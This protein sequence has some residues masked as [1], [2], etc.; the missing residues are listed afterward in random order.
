MNALAYQA[1][2]ED[3]EGRDRSREIR[4]EAIDR[5]KETLILRRVTHLDQL[6]DKLNE[7]RVRRVIMPMLAGSVDWE[8]TKRDLEYVRDLGLAARASPARIANP[9]YA[10]VAPRE[11]TDSLQSGLAGQV[12]PEWYVNKDRGLDMAELLEAFQSYFREH[13]ESWVERYGHREAGPQLVLHAYL[14]RVVRRYGQV[15]REYAVGRGW[16]DLVIEWRLGGG[17]GPVPTLKHVIECKVRS[18][19]SGLEIL[20]REGREQTATYMDRCGAKSGHLVIFDVRPRKSWD[21][22]IFR[23]DPEQDARP[24]TVWEM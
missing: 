10:E 12:D 6:A 7:D 14:R 20:I 17:P 9:I 11:L 8:Y 2:F 16:S 23:T 3:D 22:R 5:A 4:V 21:E 24:I 18:E 19:E 15:G 13:A 1:C